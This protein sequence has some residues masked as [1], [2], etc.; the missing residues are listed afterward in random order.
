MSEGLRGF[1]LVV[2]AIIIYIGLGALV[3]FIFYNLK[4]RDLF[5]GYIG[6]LVIGVIG[7]L[8]GG[9]I[10]DRLFYDIF[11]VILDF[12]SRGAGVN[13]IAGFIGAYFAVYIMNKLNHDRERKKF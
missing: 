8:I 5:G 3:A 7:A 13:I 10:L 4:R 6:G 1:L 9:L 2:K 11:V 12:L